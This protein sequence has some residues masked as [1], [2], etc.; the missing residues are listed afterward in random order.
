MA[1]PEN[2]DYW[3]LK[4]RFAEL[5]DQAP[6]ARA[7]HLAAIDAQ[8]P[9]LAAALRQR[10]RLLQAGQE[11]DDTV[12]DR[13]PVVPGY[14]VQG[15]LGTGGMGRVWRAHRQH[16]PQQR[17]ALKQLLPGPADPLQHER[18]ARERAA[19]ARL[20]HP[21]IVA[22]VDA[23]EDAAGQPF[24]VTPWVDGDRIDRWCEHHASPIR[25]RVRLIRDIAGALAH[26][27][28]QLIV[29]R[30]LKPANVLVDRS[31]QVRLLD[32]GIARRLDAGAE[33]TATGLSL[34]TLRYA[35]PEQVSSAAIGPA[36]D[37][38]A[39]GVLL[40]ELLAGCSPYPETTHPAALTQAIATLDPPPPSLR[41]NRPQEGLRGSAGTDLD[42]IVLKLL[43]KQPQ[44]RYASA[45][46]LQ[47]E[48]DRW[49]AGAAV[50]ARSGERGYLFRRWLRRWRWALGAAA[51]GLSLLGAQL[52]QL[53]RAL[54]ATARERDR[55]RAIADYFVQLFR[56]AGPGEAREGAISART[57]LDRSVAQLD[58]KPAVGTDT[59]RGV[60]ELVSGRV[61]ADLGLIAPAEPLLA[62]AIERL[63]AQSPAPL[64]DLIDAYRH[65]A[66]VLYQ[67]DRV[68]A[69]LARS[70]A[71]IALL[72]RRGEDDSERY[73]GMLQNA[74]I[75]AGTLGD[76]SAAA[77]L[78]T[79]ALDILERQ[80]EHARRAYILL[81]LNLGGEAASSNAT[82][83]ALRYF[84]RASAALPA[85]APPDTD[86]ALSVQ[87]A[88][89][90][91]RLDL[92]PSSDTRR[93]VRAAIRTALPLALRHYG[94]SHVETAF[95]HEL[96]G[97]AA[98]LDD[99]AVQALAHWQAAHAAAIPLFPDAQH[100]FRQR[101]AEQ[102]LLARLL[103]GPVD[104]ALRA[105]I[106]ALAEGG[107][108]GLTPT[109]LAAADCRL[110]ADASSAQAFEAAL[111][112]PLAAA[113]PRWQQR[114]WARWMCAIP[115]APN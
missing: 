77:A 68:P 102:E 2:L 47:N 23:G 113:L 30:D 54:A 4:R 18:F 97:I 16:E 52:W 99:D 111:R 50:L 40:Y 31:G 6:A 5:L 92:D 36:C 109:L 104:A 106:A 34:M 55:A 57:L 42:A 20:N 7:A 78:Y 87:R 61:Y 79:R 75:A 84:E 86:L 35:A 60:L 32:F 11:A 95:W 98:L 49:L 70:Q 88:L 46:E 67:L 62:A 17:L 15:L 63:E 29:H 71:A 93:E 72:E 83:S 48:L 41:A 3:Q 22:L 112:A 45:Q 69:S 12:A 73:A 81:L 33:S 100:A 82:T 108:T 74:A 110:Q 115:A 94:A 90:G 21:H 51:L 65:H 89:L 96:A 43:R 14:V 19:L 26:A 44:E 1:D 39:L 38:Y 8:T 64:D 58:A 85:L 10:L 114:V 80:P 37:L 24:L 9:R 101:F 27:H 91:T 13:A 53:D 28:S 107:A 66:A 76:A 56:Q 105:E 25:E 103:H 59:N